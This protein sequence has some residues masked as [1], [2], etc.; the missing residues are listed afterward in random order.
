[1][2]EVLLVTGPLGSGR[3]TAVNRLLKAEL[4]RGGRVAVLINEFGSVSVD[5]ILL[6]AA[7]PELA[8]IANLVDGCACCSL[9][10][11]V[12]KVLADWA[13]LPEGRRPGR[14]VLETTG[15]ADPTDLVDLEEDPG[16]VA[17]RPEALEIDD[18][19]EYQPNDAARRLLSATLTLDA[20]IA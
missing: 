12:V 4:A 18:L 1:M 7:R 9:K 15:L 5:G 14:V 16:L 8:D 6:D 11:D 17:A 19:H 10:A 3:T 20:V 13:A 2:L